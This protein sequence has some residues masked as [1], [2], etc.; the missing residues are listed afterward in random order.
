M[1][2]RTRLKSL[3]SV[4]GVSVQ[5][6]TLLHS[7][8]VPDSHDHDVELQRAH[9]PL[10]PRYTRSSS[11]H[12]SSQVSSSH[13]AHAAPSP[14]LPSPSHIILCRCRNRH[15]AH[16]SSTTRPRIPEPLGDS[17]AR[18]DAGRATPRSSAQ[19]RS[20]RIG[21]CVSLCLPAG[22][23]RCSRLPTP[24]ARHSQR[25]HSRPPPPHQPP[26]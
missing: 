10:P 12:P 21:G 23:P 20:Q 24:V 25:E 19:P 2:Q 11:H 26:R 7:Y 3:N 6:P 22:P 9:S 15:I 8:V 18:S 1:A 13:S 16:V 4:T 5:Q 17:P 14:P